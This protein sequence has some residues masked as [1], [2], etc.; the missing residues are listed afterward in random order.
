MFGGET[1]GS[2]EPVVGVFFDVAV[3]IGFASELKSIRSEARVRG[4]RGVGGEGEKVES[5]RELEDE[6]APSEG[7]TPWSDATVLAVRSG[8]I[9]DTCV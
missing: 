1:K 2:P 7:L 5:A 8:F 6:V 9:G 3:I 4:V